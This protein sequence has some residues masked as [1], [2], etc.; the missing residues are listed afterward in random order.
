MFNYHYRLESPEEYDTTL[1]LSDDGDDTDVQTK[2]TELFDSGVI[3]R[4]LHKILHVKI[5]VVFKRAWPVGVYF[6]C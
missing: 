2:D 6:N 1:L 3:K 5:V 4:Y